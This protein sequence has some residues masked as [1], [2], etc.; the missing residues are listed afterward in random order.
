MGELAY[1]IISADD[2]YSV[3]IGCVVHS[4][5]D[6]DRGRRIRSNIPGEREE[7]ERERE[8]E[9]E[10]ESINIAAYYHWNSLLVNSA[11]F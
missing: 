8:R 4:E 7:R 3:F 1:P 11:V 6:G 10:M 5:Y 9:R 2:A